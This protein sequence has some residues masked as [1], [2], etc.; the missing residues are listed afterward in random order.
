[1]TKQ[2]KV[3]YPHPPTPTLPALRPAMMVL[4]EKGYTYRAIKEW[5]KDRQILKY[6]MRDVSITCNLPPRKLDLS[7]A[8]HVISNRLADEASGAKVYR[9]NSQYSQSNTRD[10]KNVSAGGLR[11]RALKPTILILKAKGYTYKEIGAWCGEQ[12]LRSYTSKMME[13]AVHGTG[14]MAKLSAEQTKWVACVEAAANAE[15]AK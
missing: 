4:R 8:E 9:Q 14:P 10:S 5:L 15:V 13:G 1:M 7:L 2:I 6:D 12:G 11:P 3:K